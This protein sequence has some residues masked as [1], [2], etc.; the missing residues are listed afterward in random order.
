MASLA[1]RRLR[2]TPTD[3]EMRLWA[4]LRR[5]Q[6]EGARFRRQ[7]PIGPYV[8][9]FACFAERLVVE[10]D[11]GQHAHQQDRDT[12]RTAWLETQGFRVLRFWNH[13]V[14]GNIEGVAERI[15]GALRASPLPGPP[16]Q[17]GRG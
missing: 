6:I 10:V 1:A 16:P 14:L 5:R 4:V 7:A 9:D 11:G 3:A 8:V 12:A 17:G 15:A 13:E 2:K